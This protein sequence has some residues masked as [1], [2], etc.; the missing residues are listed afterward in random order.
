MKKLLL[1]FFILIFLK[2]SATDT[3]K[4]NL[5]AKFI[6]HDVC[7]NQNII[8]SNQTTTI[9]SNITYNWD[10]GDGTFSTDK[11]PINKK[12]KTYGEDYTFLIKLFVNANNGCI[13]TFN[14]I[15]TING[16]PKIKVEKVFDFNLPQNISAFEVKYSNNRNLKNI[17]WVLPNNDIKDKDTIHILNTIKVIKNRVLA[18]ATNH[19]NCIGKDSTLFFAVG[20]IKSLKQNP[21]IQFEN[22]TNKNLILKNLSSN[23]SYAIVSELG[24]ILKNGVLKE[25]INEINFSN[26]GIYFLET[27]DNNGIKY[28]QKIIVLHF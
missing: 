5:M 3:C 7:E 24:I 21:N 6:T 8:L 9:Y 17:Q 25:G 12:Y 23:T 20:N 14:K 22:P 19:Q 16:E 27:Q 18:I 10:F 2:A 15:I 26:S 13:D 1:N 4:L 28:Y 11:L